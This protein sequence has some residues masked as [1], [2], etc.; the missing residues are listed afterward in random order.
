MREERSV[1]RG[2]WR[3]ERSGRR[4][5]RN[6]EERQWEERERGREWEE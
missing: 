4:E 5:D 6:W 3:E 2:V 1:K